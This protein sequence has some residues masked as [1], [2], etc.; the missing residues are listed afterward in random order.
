ML[1]GRVESKDPGK[2]DI[3]YFRKTPGWNR[4]ETPSRFIPAL[5]CAHFLLLPFG[6]LHHMELLRG[7]GIKQQQRRDG[8]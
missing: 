3:P 2:A 5:P 4:M 6:S 8:S 1:T 7:T